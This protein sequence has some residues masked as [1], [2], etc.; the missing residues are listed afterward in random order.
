KIKP[1]S[2]LVSLALEAPA[3]GSMSTNALPLTA[4]A[5]P[6]TNSDGTPVSCASAPGNAGSFAWVLSGLAFIGLLGRRSRRSAVTGASKNL[7]SLGVV[8][9]TAALVSGCT[10]DAASIGKGKGNGTGGGTGSGTAGDPNIVNNGTPG[11]GSGAGAGGALPQNKALFESTVQPILRNT[12]TAK[13]SVCHVPGT[14]SSVSFLAAAPA[15]DYTTITSYANVVGTFEK[16]K[17]PIMIPPPAFHAS[18]Q[19]GPNDLTT[20]GAWLDAEYAAR[21]AT[22]NNPTT[23]PGAVVKQM[24]SKFSG[25]MDEAT[26]NA[27]K[28]GQAWAQLNTNEG[29]CNACHVN[30][31]AMFIASED[32]ARMFKVVS[33]H[34]SFIKQFFSVNVTDPANPKMEVNLS[35]VNNALANQGLQVQHPRLQNGI[36]P[37]VLGG[38]QQVTPADNNATKALQRFFDAT[39]VKMNA[40]TC[41][42]ARI[43]P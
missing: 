36:L 19:F 27:E 40:G 10:G 3:P 12:A 30:G 34:P 43:K 5:S 17:A 11:S 42:T 37:Q 25:C 26:W 22:G 7:L 15:N 8:V 29:T 2:K 1:D 28:V 39:M 18:V 35:R 14:V 31:E 20:I 13:C 24:L 6:F 33:S 9:L 32:S 16:A 23:G 38:G 41:G 4:A 21:S